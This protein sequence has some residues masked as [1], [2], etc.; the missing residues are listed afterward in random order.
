MLDFLLLTVEIPFST[1]YNNNKQ[2]LYLTFLYPGVHRRYNSK[3]SSTYVKN[4]TEFA[5]RYGR[6]S[7][8]GF[9]SEDTVSVSLRNRHTA[10][11]TACFGFN[12]YFHCVR[13]NR[14]FSLFLAGRRSFCARSAVWRSSEAAW[15]H[16]CCC[17]VRWG[18]GD[19][20]SLHIGS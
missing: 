5:I 6:G 3:N 13:I 11:R 4:G 14:H 9:I 15:H 7:L 10:F 8:S 18:F 16:I 1:L 20:V 19:G 17:T 12:D 2:M